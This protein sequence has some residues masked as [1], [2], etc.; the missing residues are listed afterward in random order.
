[1]HVYLPL[2]SRDGDGHE[3]VVVDRALVNAMS[4][5]ASKSPRSCRLTRI[6]RGVQKD[7]RQEQDKYIEDVV[8]QGQALTGTE[9]SDEIYERINRKNPNAKSYTRGRK[10]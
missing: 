9:V 1:M 3:A 6:A 10:S 5:I 2:R 8:F 4:T 7:A